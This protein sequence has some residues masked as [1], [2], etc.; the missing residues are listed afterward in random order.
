MTLPLGI[1]VRASST[2]EKLSHYRGGAGMPRSSQD[3]EESAVLWRL[4]A[5][6]SGHRIA[7]LYEDT[8]R[9][10]A[11][12]VGDGGP[13]MIG[14]DADGDIT[15]ERFLDGWREGD[16]AGLSPIGHGVLR[17]L[18]DGGQLWLGAAY[19]PGPGEVS[20]FHVAAPGGPG[21]STDDPVNRSLW[22]F[23]AEHVMHELSVDAV[24]AT[25]TAAIGTD[26]GP[27]FDDYVCGWPG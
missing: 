4:L 2:W 9:L 1:A 17:C 15:F 5:T 27:S 14:G 16:V 24:P 3:R 20:F 21:N 7:A 8:S 12:Y 22:R 10:N 13:D 11:L 26:G 18:E 19:G 23:L 6:H 25:P